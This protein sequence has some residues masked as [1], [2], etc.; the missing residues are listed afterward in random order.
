MSIIPLCAPATTVQ[1]A[2]PNV[3]RPI[4]LEAVL[5]HGRISH[6]HDHRNHIT[7]TC[8]IMF[9]CY[10]SIAKP[11]WLAKRQRRQLRWVDVPGMVDSG[12]QP[13]PPH[14]RSPGPPKGLNGDKIVS[15]W[16]EKGPD[17]FVLQLSCTWA[18]ATHGTTVAAGLGSWNG[19]AT[20]WNAG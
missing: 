13:H 11:E 15:N 6:D 18:P 10:P 14:P 17:E 3:A 16:V 4:R 9:G 20:H 12:S 5:P 19:P 7:A 8:N 1:R 2:A